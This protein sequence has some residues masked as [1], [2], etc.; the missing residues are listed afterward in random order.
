MTRMAGTLPSEASTTLSS[1]LRSRFGRPQKP[2][3]DGELSQASARPLRPHVP[4]GRGTSRN[5]GTFAL[6][7]LAQYYLRPLTR[8]S[9]RAPPGCPYR[10]QK[11][12]PNPVFWDTLPTI[13]GFLHLGHSRAPDVGLLVMARRSPAAPDT[14]TRP[15]PRC[16]LG[17]ASCAAKR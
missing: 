2:E 3:A 4:D 9:R 10:V 17:D 12:E 11:H 6:A 14:P 13:S 8:R 16:E 15:A 1:T 7:R 5:E